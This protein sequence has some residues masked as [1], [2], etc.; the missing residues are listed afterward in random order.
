MNK[1]LAGKVLAHLIA[2]NQAFCFVDGLLMS[3]EQCQ[4]ILA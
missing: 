1:E 4:E 3:R 2:T